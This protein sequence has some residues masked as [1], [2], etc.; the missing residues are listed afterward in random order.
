MKEGPGVTLDGRRHPTIPNLLVSLLASGDGN[1]GLEGLF[2]QA[3]ILAGLGDLV[4]VQGVTRMALNRPYRFKD[5]R[6]AASIV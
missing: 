1:R 4:Y 5:A 6:P 2:L 3:A